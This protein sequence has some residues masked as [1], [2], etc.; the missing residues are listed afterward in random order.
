[1]ILICRNG[2]NMI[3]NQGIA[4]ADD[5]PEDPE[6]IAVVTVE[7]IIGTKPHKAVMV[8][9]N[10]GNRIIGKAVFYSE[11][12]RGVGIAGLSSRHKDAK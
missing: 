8:P 4:V 9:E 1:M 6:R 5:I 3:I 10:A 11:T 2:I 12:A 7:S